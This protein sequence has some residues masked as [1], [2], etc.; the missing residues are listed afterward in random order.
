[1]NILIIGG[2]DGIGLHLAKYY[3]SIGANVAIV[4]RSNKNL[5]DSL[6][7]FFISADVSHDMGID[8]L[9]KEHFTVLTNLDTLVYTPGYYRNLTFN[10]LSE[11][12][13]LEHFEVNNFAFFKILKRVMKKDF[14]GSG[15][16]KTIIYISSLASLRIFKN[17]LAYST[18][19]SSTNHL[20][21]LLRI[22][23]AF[24][25]VNLV[26]VFPGFVETKMVENNNFKMPFIISPERA[27]SLIIKGLK[28]GKLDIYFPFWLSSYVRFSALLSPKIIK[29]LERL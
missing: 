22:D 13:Y 18:S 2:S 12:E 6:K 29:Y 3:K 10:E 16:L 19:K 21:D 26:R 1:M 28:K 8:N 27:A 15:Q 4:G 14:T 25:N 9:F 24:K 11:R 17:S 23:P 5:P 20:I 7:D